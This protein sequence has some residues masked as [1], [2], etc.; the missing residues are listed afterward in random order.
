MPEV[1]PRVS[2][3]TDSELNQGFDG[4]LLPSTPNGSDGRDGNGMLTANTVSSILQ[5]LKT[6]KAIPVATSA[7]AEAYVAKQTEFLKKVKA[8]YCFYDSRYKFC[9]EKLF[10]A[11]RQ[12]YQ[13]NSREAQSI[14]QKHLLNTQTFNQRVNDLTQIINAITEDGLQASN[15]IDQDIKNF[16]ETIQEQKKKLME[17]YALI[18]SS[19]ATT[20]IRKQMVKY[21]EEKAR[22]SDNLLKMYGFLN[23]VALGLLVYIYRAVPE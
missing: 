17:Q 23:I 12:G 4:G 13:N 9:L 1:C 10:A 20:T 5:T 21:T 14:I 16:N 3:L 8:E 18:H 2:S 22:R 15:N 6:A 19:Q 7:D 11:V